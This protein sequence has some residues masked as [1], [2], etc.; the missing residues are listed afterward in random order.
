MITPSVPAVATEALPDI[1]TPPGTL[2]VNVVTEPT[3]TVAIPDVAPGFTF[4]DT[5]SV[6]LQPV[7]NV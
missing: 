7:L 4:T 1:H 3:H 2:F 5:G 6:L